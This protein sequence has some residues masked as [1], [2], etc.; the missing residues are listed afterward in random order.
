[1]GEP[2]PLLPLGDTNYLGTILQTLQRSPVSPLVVVLGAHAARVREQL[3]LDGVLTVDNEDWQRGMLSSLQ[4]GVQTLLSAAPSARALLM[5][6]V[7]SPRFSR[8]TVTAL[9]TEF[10]RTDAPIVQPACGGEHGHPILLS[11]AIWPEVLAAGDE[12]G[13]REVVEAHR[14]SARVVA[15]DDPW[16]LRDADT[17]AEHRRMVER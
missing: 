8:A 12:R 13:P 14:D 2:K 7:D 15:V 9:V 17:P 4:A 1:M 3:D 6:L 5:C 10:L 11:R 16:I